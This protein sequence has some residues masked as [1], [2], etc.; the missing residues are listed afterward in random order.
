ME[1]LQ[2]I[3]LQNSEKIGANSL[4]NHLD[5]TVMLLAWNE[6]ENLKLVLPDIHRVLKGAGLRYEILIVD[7]GSKDNTSRTAKELG[8]RVHVQTKKGY[9]GA[10]VEGFELALGDYIVTMD[11]DYS[12]N[13]D[14]IVDLWNAREK[15]DALVAS[16]YVTGGSSEGNWFRTLL[17]RVLNTVYRRVLSLPIRDLSSGY[18]MY[19]REVLSEVEVLSTNF[20]ALEEIIVKIYGLGYPISEVPFRFR[21]REEGNSKAKILKFGW[22]LLKTLHRLWKMRNDAH[23]ADYDYR[24]YDSPIFLQRYW[25]RTRHRLVMEMLGKTDKVLDIGCG[26]SRIVISIPGCI[27]IDLDLN[28]LRFISKKGV[29]STRASVYSLPYADESFDQVIFSQVI[30]H[31]PLKPQIMWEIRRVLKPGGTLIIGTPDF[32]RLFWIILE[33]IYDRVA[34]SAY[35][36]EHITRFTMASFRRLIL[37]AGFEIKRARYVGG[38]ELIIKATKLPDRKPIS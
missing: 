19:R 11:A 26:S 31:I 6:E 15:G 1:K 3:E 10:L 34:P 27:G 29:R 2:S 17:S 14:F 24:A 18:R 7:A 37:E 30:E 20:D 12:H 23:W 32:G 22:Q 36:H 5:V 9:G 8:A 28:K 4:K 16:R 25:Q 21:A 35:G 13:P 33:E 38:G